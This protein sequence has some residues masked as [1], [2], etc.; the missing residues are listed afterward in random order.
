VG[1]PLPPRPYAT[2]GCGSP[3]GDY[4]MKELFVPNMEANL[5]ISLAAF[6]VDKVIH[7]TDGCG[8][9]I[10]ITI[11]GK[12]D[13]E[14]QSDKI[15]VIPEP[16]VQLIT[17]KLHLIDAETK[18]ERNRKIAEMLASLGGMMTVTISGTARITFST[19]GRPENSTGNP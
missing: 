6:V 8:H 10:K 13:T 14:T 19:K 7:N 9:P 3:L 11:V 15:V 4:L 18:S 16:N 12:P 17:E 1:I 5:G 2:I